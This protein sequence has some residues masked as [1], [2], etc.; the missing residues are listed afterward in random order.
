MWGMWGGGGGLGGR[1][2]GCCGRCGVGCD[3]ETSGAGALRQCGCLESEGFGGGSGA[4][5]VA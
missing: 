3:M 5:G 1:G 4:Q 2:G